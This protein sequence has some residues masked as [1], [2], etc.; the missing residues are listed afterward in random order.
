MRALQAVEHDGPVRRR[1]HLRQ[2][3]ADSNLMQGVPLEVVKSLRTKAQLKVWGKCGRRGD[4]GDVGGC[5]GA[6]MGEEEGVWN[7]R[8][9]GGKR[10]VLRRRCGRCPFLQQ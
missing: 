7:V 2:I 4:S 3:L 5:D 8:A 1:P 9:G 10:T 6:G